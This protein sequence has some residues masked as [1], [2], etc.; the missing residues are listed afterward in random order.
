MPDNRKPLI[1]GAFPICRNYTVRAYVRHAGPPEWRGCENRV[2]N[3]GP[4]LGRVHIGYLRPCDY[5]GAEEGGGDHGRGAG[6]INVKG[7][8][9]R[10]TSCGSCLY[11]IINHY[12]PYPFPYANTSVQLQ[13]SSLCSIRWLQSWEQHHIVLSYTHCV[14]AYQT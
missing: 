3:A 11:F 7:N 6:G 4:L 2:W 10:W 14:C 12:P 1:Y 13:P 8:C 5:C 9:R